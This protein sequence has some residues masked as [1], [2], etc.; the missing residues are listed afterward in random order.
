MATHL[1]RRR[2]VYYSSPQNS[3]DLIHGF[4]RQQVMLSLRTKDRAEGL[5]S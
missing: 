5:Q 2:G 1:P 4:G 3:Q